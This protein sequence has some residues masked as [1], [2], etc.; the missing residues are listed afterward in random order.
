M[1]NWKR[2]LINSDIELTNDQINILLNG[3]TSLREALAMQY[4][5]IKYGLLRNKE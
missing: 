3:S 2:K 4:L 5:K 1:D